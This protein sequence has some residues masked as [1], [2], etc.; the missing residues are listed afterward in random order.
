MSHLSPLM[1]NRALNMSSLLTF[2]FPSIF[3]QSYDKLGQFA[4]PQIKAGGLTIYQLLNFFFFFLNF[5]LESI[6]GTDQIFLATYLESS[7]KRL[8]QKLTLGRMANNHL[9]L[10]ARSLNKGPSFHLLGPHTSSKR[11]EYRMKIHSRQWA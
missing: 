2:F 10:V 7:A 5:P 11:D 1:R 8:T 4:F 6:I 3:R 9:I